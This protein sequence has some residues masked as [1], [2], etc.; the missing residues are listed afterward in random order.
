MHPHLWLADCYLAWLTRPPLSR[1]GRLQYFSS[2]IHIAAFPC[3]VV[4]DALR[5]VTITM[6]IAYES[7][8][9]MVILH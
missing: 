1:L 5:G 6:S 9:Y 7:L 3:D 4:D 2:V 8:N